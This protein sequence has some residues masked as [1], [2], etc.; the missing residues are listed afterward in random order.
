MLLLYSCSSLSFQNRFFQIQQLTFN[1]YH[2]LNLPLLIY[3]YGIFPLS[4]Q[5]TSA[6]N[7]P[8]K[9]INT[10]LNIKCELKVFLKA[11]EK[12]LRIIV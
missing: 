1:Y 8:I 5:Y 10:V 6:I 2:I 4:Q 3:S 11:T 12:I 9:Q 7:K